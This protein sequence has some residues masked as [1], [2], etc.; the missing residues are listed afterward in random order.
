VDANVVK[1]DADTPCETVES[2][3]DLINVHVRNRLVTGYKPLIGGI[4]R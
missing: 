3:R 1:D 4:T 2:I